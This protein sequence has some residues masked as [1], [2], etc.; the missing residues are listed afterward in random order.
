M[1]ASLATTGSFLH[2]LTEMTTRV[3]AMSRTRNW[4]CDVVLRIG[5]VAT[6]RPIAKATGHVSHRNPLIL[7]VMAKAKV[8]VRLNELLDK[9]LLANVHLFQ[10]IGTLIHGIE[11]ILQTTNVVG[12]TL[13]DHV[14]LLCNVGDLTSQ[15]V[16]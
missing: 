13:V 6:I 7:L 15:S 4:N 2:C 5:R 8:L 12:D 14:H 16:R 3:D 9:V 10:T 1:L 11:T